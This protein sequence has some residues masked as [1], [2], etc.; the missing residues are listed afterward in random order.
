M[1]LGHLLFLSGLSRDAYNSLNRRGHLAFL[2]KHVGEGVDRYSEAHAL[3]MA[4]FHYLRQLGLSPELAASA[5]HDSWPDIM[6][7]AGLVDGP[8][9]SKLCGGRINDLGIYDSWGWPHPKDNGEP[10]L[11]SSAVDLEKLWAW[12]QPNLSEIRKGSE[13]LAVTSVT[14]A[15]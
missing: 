8:I 2:Q 5:V 12:L 6:R 4:A 14:E 13:G 9:K 15:A 3:G 1:K 7:V 10:P 11:A